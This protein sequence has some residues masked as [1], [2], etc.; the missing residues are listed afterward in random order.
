MIYIQHGQRKKEKSKEVVL[1]AERIKKPNKN[2][3]LFE[4]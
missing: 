3:C 2:G 4:L 1:L